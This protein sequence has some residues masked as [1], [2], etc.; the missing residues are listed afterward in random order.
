MNPKHGWT[1]EMIDAIK[2]CETYNSFPIRILAQDIDYKFTDKEYD[3]KNKF[4]LVKSGTTSSISY[5]G[6][7]GSSYFSYTFDLDDS[8]SEIYKLL[9]PVGINIEFYDH[10]TRKFE[11]LSSEAY[12]YGYLAFRNIGDLP[13]LDIGLNE[14]CGIK[15][16]L[17]DLFIKSKIFNHKYLYMGIDYDCGFVKDIKYENFFIDEHHINLVPI[18]SIKLDERF[19]IGHFTKE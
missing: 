13:A 16:K 19:M 17:D 8:V 6:V 7:F 18:K 10:S 9:G 15:E 4:A 5:E 1:K 2:D 11:E 14:E 12:K 3:E